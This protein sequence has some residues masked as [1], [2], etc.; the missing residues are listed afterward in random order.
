MARC[1]AARFVFAHAGGAV[2]FLALRIARLTARSEFAACVPEGVLAELRRLHF[3]TAL[4]A[5]EFAFGPLLRLTSAS[6]TAPI[7][8]GSLSSHYFTGSCAPNDGIEIGAARIHAELLCCLAQIDIIAFEDEM[9]WSWPGLV[10]DG[11][12][13]HPADT[14]G[15]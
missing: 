8:I 4:A 10:T 2:P 14:Y 3:D 6:S 9:T 12:Q 5:N 7:A 15:I 13:E 11:N 1:R